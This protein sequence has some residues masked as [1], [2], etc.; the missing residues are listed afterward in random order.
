MKWTLIAL[1]F[2]NVLFSQSK[3]KTIFDVARSGTVLEL[4]E[5]LK[6]NPN[7]VDEISENGYSPLILAT[8]RNNIEVA[9]ILLKKTKDINFLS[10][11]GT[12]LMAAAM[13]GNLE[14]TQLI[15]SQ[16]ANL[17][18][19][20]S[21]GATALMLAISTQNIE[22]IKEILKAGPDLSVR[23]N[24]QKQAIDY[25]LKSNNNSIINLFQ[26]EK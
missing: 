7:C 15:L 23:D 18:L 12:A 19:Q 13:R 22:I 8:Y 4:N 26:N 21:A 16:K 14:M 11:S 6:N 1:M 10:N 17:N 5:L 24:F 20:D 3:P 9:K 25:A 2:V